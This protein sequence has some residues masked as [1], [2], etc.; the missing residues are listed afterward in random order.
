MES[1]FIF[2]FVRQVQVINVA[3]KG[4]NKSAYRKNPYA[5]FRC[6]HDSLDNSDVIVARGAAPLQGALEFFTEKFMRQL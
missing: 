3:F 4:A 5:G 1:L 2:I 6:F